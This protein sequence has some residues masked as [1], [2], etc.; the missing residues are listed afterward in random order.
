M[1]MA[2]LKVICCV[3]LQ[4]QAASTNV[5]CAAL[6]ELIGATGLY[7]NNC[8]RCESSK[9]A[10]DRKVAQILWQ[11]STS[12]IQAVISSGEDTAAVDN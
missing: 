6:P 1:G 4:Q 2:H 3:C 12:L 7:F 5:Y 9:V 8:C 10:Q 11:L